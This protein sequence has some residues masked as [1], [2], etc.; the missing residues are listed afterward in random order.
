MLQGNKTNANA[1]LQQVN[2]EISTG[3]F[4]MS[5]NAL[6]LQCNTNYA[7]TGFEPNSLGVYTCSN[8]VWTPTVPTCNG[9]AV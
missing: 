1:C 9:N 4:K 8:G 7:A 5:C 2:V 6:K 3:I